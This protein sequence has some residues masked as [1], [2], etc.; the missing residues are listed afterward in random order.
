[1]SRL[2]FPSLE[3]SDEEKRRFT[4]ADVHSKLL[5]ADLAALG[6]PSRTH[7]QAD[8]EYFLKGDPDADI[9]RLRDE[10]DDLVFDLFEIRAARDEV[11]RFYRTVGRVEP[12]EDQAAS[13]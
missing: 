13:E 8:G 1:M 12:P 2:R 4:E 7:T 3:I 9:Q 5:E 10:I 6:Y 11:R